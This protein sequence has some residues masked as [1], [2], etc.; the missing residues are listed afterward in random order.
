[1]PYP[2]LIFSQSDYLILVVH[3]NSYTEWQIV[4]IQ[5]SWLLQLIWIYTVC[6]GRVYPGSAG[7]GLYLSMCLKLLKHCRRPWSDAAFCGV[8]SRFTLF[9]QASTSGRVANFVDPDQTPRSAASESEVT[10]FAQPCTSRRVSNI[11]ADQD[12]TPHNAASD[13]GLHCLLS[14]VLL[15]EWQTL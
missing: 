5:I 2:F 12:Q 9:A 4:Q 14:F 11:I 15:D 6:K 1:M 3:T 10:L 13:L 8:W 7:Q